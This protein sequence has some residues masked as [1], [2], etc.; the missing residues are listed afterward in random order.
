MTKRSKY[1]LQQ[2]LDEVKQTTPSFYEGQIFET[3]KSIY[4]ST[5]TPRYKKNI[6][7]KD[8]SFTKPLASSRKAKENFIKEG[9]PVKDFFKNTTKGDFLRVVETDGKVAKCINLSLKEDIREDYYSNDEDNIIFDYFM[10]ANGTVK[11][12]KRKNVDKYFIEQ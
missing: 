8:I 3:L 1:T 5:K 12:F 7:Y 10:I 6:T 4:P 11:H 2:L 9:S